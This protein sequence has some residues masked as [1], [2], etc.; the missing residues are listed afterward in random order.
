MVSLK[1]FREEPQEGQRELFVM[2]GIRG[3]SL[4]LFVVFQWILGKYFGNLIYLF[5]SVA[6]YFMLESQSCLTIVDHD[7]VTISYFNISDRSA[8]K[9]WCVF[10]L[11]IEFVLSFSNLD[12]YDVGDAG[13]F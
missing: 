1:D 11:L 13:S 6:N 8:R 9:M 5:A 12:D 10:L 2:S 3:K 4:R 7:R